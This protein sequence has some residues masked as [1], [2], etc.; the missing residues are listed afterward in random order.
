MYTY[1]PIPEGTKLATSAKCDF[2]ARGRICIRARLRETL[3]IS[4][5][6]LQAQ[7]WHIHR[8]GTYIRGTA[9]LTLLV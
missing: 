7:K 6:A 2:C 8:S 4:L 9:C 1:T 3:R 5:R